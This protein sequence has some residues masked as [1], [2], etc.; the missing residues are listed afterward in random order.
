MVDQRLR[1]D[2]AAFA[3][4]GKLLG[5]AEDRLQRFVFVREFGQ[6]VEALRDV[7]DPVVAPR[8]GEGRSLGEGKTTMP[9]K[10]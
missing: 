2:D 5:F 3:V 4:E 7:L 9:A 10:V 6:A 1:E 8:I